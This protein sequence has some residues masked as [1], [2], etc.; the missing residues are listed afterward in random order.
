MVSNQY[1]ED[2]YEYYYKKTQRVGLLGFGN[3]LADRQLEK[4]WI[5]DKIVNN[6]LELG[7][8]TGDHLAFVNK[9]T[10]RNYYG[11]DIIKPDDVSKFFPGFKFIQANVENI[12]F[13]DKSF[14]RVSSLCLLHHVPNPLKVLHEVRR[15]LKPGGELAIEMPCDPGLLNTLLKKIITYPRM[16][17][18]G[19]NN[20]ELIYAL[21]HPNK[22]KSLKVLIQEVYKKDFV[23]VKYFPFKINSTNFNLFLIFH[24]TKTDKE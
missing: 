15:V 13:K 8:T 9:K 11:T 16:K 24:I 5:N 4:Y 19:V 23:R 2:Y 14:D 20:P 21:E 12:P 10:I 7:V 1:L 17:K 3:S 18:N 6:H 22:V